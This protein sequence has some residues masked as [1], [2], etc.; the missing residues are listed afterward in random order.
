VSDAHRL[1]ALVFCLAFAVAASGRAYAQMEEAD[2]PQ[3]VTTPAGPPPTP[4]HTGIKAMATGI[5]SD[6]KH[7][8]S[9]ENLFWAAT[10]GG[11]ALAVHPLDDN[12]NQALVG[13]SG[14]EKF[15]K[16]GEVLG[17]LYTLLGT[18]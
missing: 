15:F 9:T 17:S 16:P 11:L 7:L 1:R 4:R 14:A 8:P 13:N 5:V 3:V 2:E 10:G 6:L 18:A 12:V